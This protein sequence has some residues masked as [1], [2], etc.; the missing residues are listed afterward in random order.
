M[1]PT[2]AKP[3]PL[4]PE[5]LLPILTAAYDLPAPVGCAPLSSGLND[6]FWVT[7]GGE[8]LILKVYRA[9]WRTAAEVREEMGALRHLDRRGVRVALPV[10]RR[11]GGLVGTLPAP[12][13]E[14]ATV[15]MTCAPGEGL[16]AGEEAGCRRFGGA[17]AEVHRATDGLTEAPVQYD[18]EHLVAEPLAAL[19]PYLEDRP[20]DRE[21]LRALAGR[22]SER[23]ER[24]GAGALD[25][26]Y[27]HGDFRAANLFWDAA[28]GTV[29]L[30]DFELGGLGFRAYDIAYAQ[31]T[32]HRM[33]LELLWGAPPPQNDER[34]W[35]A[36]LCGYEERRPLSPGDR[37]AIPLFAAMRPLQL[38]GTLLATARQ[39]RPGQETWPPTRDE[40][41][42][43]GGD[44]FDRALRFLRAWEAAHLAQ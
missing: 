21:F 5:A 23:I 29:T 15:L 17:L 40:R 4:F 30:F 28:T 25:W 12:F 11:D 33:A 16:D 31:M 34:L 41:G 43:P 39:R 22:L 2:D 44:L 18:L 7:T 6:L 36:F 9:G 19:E 1:K 27:C 13:P 3:S 20:A 10:A 42:L 37:A 38:M 24:L 8:T 14:R 26:G 32:I 35:A